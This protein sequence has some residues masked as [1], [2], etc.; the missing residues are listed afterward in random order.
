M[1]AFSPMILL[2]GT[3]LKQHCRSPL[4]QLFF[5]AFFPLIPVDVELLSAEDKMFALVLD[6][7]HSIKSL[8]VSALVSSAPSQVLPPSIDVESCSLTCI[9]LYFHLRQMEKLSMG[10]LCI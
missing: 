3:D 1:L 9:N 8:A 7:G 4:P 10:E 6:L 2:K 5:Q